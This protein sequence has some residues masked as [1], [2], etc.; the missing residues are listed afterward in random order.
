VRGRWHGQRYPDRALLRWL[1][2]VCL[3]RD[4]LHKSADRIQ[5]KQLSAK[6]WVFNSGVIAVEDLF[7]C[8][9]N[10]LR[11]D[12]LEEIVPRPKLSLIIPTYK[13]ADNIAGFLNAVYAVLLPVT[14]SFEVIVVDDDSPD[15]TWVIAAAMSSQLPGLRVVRRRNERGLASAV[16]RGWQAARGEIVGTINADF[17]HSP[18]ILAEMLTMTDECD[19]VIASRYLANEPTGDE[20]LYRRF[21]SR[22][23]YRLGSL[24]LPR[25]FH[26]VSDPLSGCYL[27]RR[28]AITDVTFHPIGYKTLIEILARGRVGTIGQCGYSLKRRRAGRSKATPVQYLNY[29]QQLVALKRALE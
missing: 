8:A 23:A 7:A 15:R 16:I 2:S 4:S 19:L 5:Q 6:E 12:R 26:R 10:E 25:V 14:D 28:D 22:V 1:V 18:G 17:Q 11:L 20:T 21:A 3:A 13:E 27:V 9:D 29:I 24:L